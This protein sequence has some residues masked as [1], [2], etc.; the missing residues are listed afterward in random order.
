MEDLSGENIS[1]TEPE[2]FE[3]FLNNEVLAESTKA[4]INL[5]ITFLMNS[6]IEVPKVARDLLFTTKVSELLVIHKELSKLVAPATPKTIRYLMEMQSKNSKGKYRS[7]PLIRNFIIL[8]ILSILA[9]IST[10]LSPNVNHENLSKGI[11]ANAGF[12]LFLNLIFLCS[13]SAIG[14]VFFMLSKLTT[15]VKQ[16]TFDPT[17]TSNY[18]ARLIMGIL[19]GLIMSEIIVLNQEMETASVEMNRLLFALLGGFAS[20][21]VYKILE[22]I[23][24]KIQSFLQ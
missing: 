1:T 22:A 17:E 2:Y 24:Q 7:I 21:V 13:A 6:G 20:E 15:E 18:W 8:A 14:A 3:P 4:E 10:G 19:S 12:S 9:L 23:I 16:A 11:L 5:L